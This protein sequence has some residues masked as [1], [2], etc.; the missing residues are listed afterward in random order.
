MA[1]V[2]LSAPAAAE[3]ANGRTSLTVIDCDVHPYPNTIAE[4]T[5]FMSDRWVQYIKQSGFAAPPGTQYPKGYEMASRRDAWPPNGLAARRR[6]RLRA[7]A[8]A[9][10]VGHAV[11][12]SYASLRCRPRPQR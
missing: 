2:V 12:D 9:G 10:R 11:R 7:R 3:A 4:L 1:Q 5:P 8:I 6:S